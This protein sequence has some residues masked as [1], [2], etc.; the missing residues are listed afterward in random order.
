[1]ASTGRNVTE[2]LLLGLDGVV[3]LFD[4]PLYEIV[5]VGITLLEGGL[6]ELNRLQSLGI[7]ES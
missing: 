3:D 2:V 4:A 1:M 5:D 6:E 7:K